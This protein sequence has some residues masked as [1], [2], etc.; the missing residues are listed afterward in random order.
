MKFKP[1]VSDDEFRAAEAD[2]E[3][4]T[5]EISRQA[6]EAATPRPAAEIVDRDAPVPSVCDV[7]AEIRT[8]IVEPGVG[9]RL[10]ALAG[11]RSPLRRVIDLNRI[12]RTVDLGCAAGLATR[13]RSFE[14]VAGLYSMAC[15]KSTAAAELPVILGWVQ[16]IVVMTCPSVTPAKVR[17]V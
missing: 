8:R 4:V 2:I 16:A 11:I 13:T 1:L 7:R 6:Q 17:A 12:A 15:D 3:A 10:L 14:T 9:V 5:R